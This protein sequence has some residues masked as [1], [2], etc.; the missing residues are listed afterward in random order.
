MRHDLVAEAELDLVRAV[1]NDEHLF[2]YVRDIGPEYLSSS[3]ARAIWSVIYS[4]KGKI[5]AT[6]LYNELD[7]FD[8][9][10]QV[11]KEYPKL[12][13][14]QVLWVEGSRVGD[15][16][17]ISAAIRQEYRRRCLDDL[18]LHRPL[19]MTLDEQ[20]M[21][22]TR[23][24]RALSAEDKTADTIEEAHKA[25][26]E[27]VR[28]FLWRQSNPNA[29][30]GWKVG[31]KQYDKFLQGMGGLEYGKMMVIAGMTGTG[32]TN[33]LIDKAINLCYNRNGS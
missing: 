15:I 4:N 9:G 19:Y 5:S 14:F 18:V 1:L 32:K 20:I 30:I 31:D 13:N 29:C 26:A 17:V 12:E 8:D 28:E 22:M 23:G 25:S 7:T 27:I 11:Y 10:R 21:W 33:W 3:V 2:R 24:L 16:E 6:T